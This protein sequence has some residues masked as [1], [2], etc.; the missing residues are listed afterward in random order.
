MKRIIIFLLP[1]FFMACGQSNNTETNPTTIGG[2]RDLLE[3]KKKE[4]KQLEMEISELTEDLIE[5]DPSLEKKKKTVTTT[6]V[7]TSPF[8][9]YINLQGVVIADKSA[10]AVSET[11]GRIISLKV[12]EGDYVRKGNL[13]AKL[14]LESHNKQKQEILTSL[15][16]A[17]DIFERQSRL[18]A[19]NIG[20]EVQFLQAKNNKERL[21]KSLEQVNHQLTKA[22]VYAPISGVVDREFTKLGEVASPGMPIV[23]ILNVRDVKVEVDL[24]E[25]YLA[26]LKKGMEVDVYF[27][28]LDMTQKGKV[29]LLGRTIDP[30]NRTLKFEV[31]VSNPGNILKPNLLAE[32]KLVEKNLEDAISIPLEMVQQDVNGN[33][34]VIKAKNEGDLIRAEKVIVDVNDVYESRALIDNGI[35]HGDVLVKDGA[36][37]LSDGEMILV[38]NDSTI[39]DE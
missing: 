33:E 15:E 10:N 9:K 12:K 7:T 32:L 35:T 2:K 4:L 25:R 5:N 16:L 37:L 19:Q 39:G 8:T 30:A 28:S 18:W 14:D 21:E 38:A 36:R 27:P 24:P 29:S 13:I 22:N 3:K 17:K 20:S 31:D 6:V 23:N 34:F 1:I 26:I 11:P